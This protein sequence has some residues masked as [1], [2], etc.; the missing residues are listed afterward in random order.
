MTKKIPHRHQM[1][2]IT[3]FPLYLFRCDCGLVSSGVNER[4]KPTGILKPGKPE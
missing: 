2:I 1:K 4:G 3:S